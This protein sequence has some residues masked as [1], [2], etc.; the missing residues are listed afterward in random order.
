VE[1]KKTQAAAVILSTRPIAPVLAIAIIPTDDA[2]HQEGLPYE[3]IWN[4]FFARMLLSL[5]G[6]ALPFLV[7]A[8]LVPNFLAPFGVGPQILAIAILIGVTGLTAR[9]MIRPVVALSRAAARAESGDLSVRVIPS[10]S[11]EIRLLGRA[12]NSMLQRLAGIQFR[13]RNEVVDSAGHLA[14]AAQELAD[15][16]L[17]QTTAASKTSASMEE[18]ARS[19]TS[20]AESA[21]G[22]TSQVTDVRARIASAQTELQASGERVHEMSQRVGEIEGI[23]VLINDIA[24]ETNL[25][26]LNAAIEAARAGE[27]GRGFAVVADEVRR[28]AERSKAAAAQIGALVGGAQMQAQATVT[29]VEDRRRQMELWLS[30]MVKMADASAQVQLAT[31][32][33][34]SAVDEAVEAIEQ[35]AVSSRSVSQTAQEIA[36]AA[37]RQ[38]E[39]ATELATSPDEGGEAVRCESWS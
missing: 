26:A 2:I 36:L 27:S 11:N 23:L 39:I 14:Q 17:E 19:T 12:F 38:G 15:A 30:M 13:I 25:L 21:G 32:E 20:I 31:A 1:L 6:V 8:G 34:R 4:S 33:Q 18:L 22:V 5:L 7:I 9:L 35:I 10:G 29:A 24:D 16:T 3:A 37:A 28:L